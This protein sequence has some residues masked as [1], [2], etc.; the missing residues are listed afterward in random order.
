MAV[1]VGQALQQA[2]GRIGLA[3]AEEGEHLF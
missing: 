2:A 1:P 3:G